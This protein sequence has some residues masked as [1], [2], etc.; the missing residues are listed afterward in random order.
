MEESKGRATGFHQSPPLV[1]Y[2]ERAQKR[3]AFF[4]Y[5]QGSEPTRHYAVTPE[6]RARIQIAD[7]H[8]EIMIGSPPLIPVAVNQSLRTYPATASV[9][10]SREIFRGAILLR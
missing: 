10:N 9:G 1:D 8:S 3:I 4:S 2:S 5:R 6:I 7:L